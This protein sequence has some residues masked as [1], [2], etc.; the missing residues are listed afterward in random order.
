MTEDYLQQRSTDEIQNQVDAAQSSLFGPIAAG[1]GAIAIGAAVYSTKMAGGGRLI[2]N[3]LHFLGHPGGVGLKIDEAANAAAK[4]GTAGIN[5]VLTANISSKTGRLFL[6]P[7]DLISDTRSALDLINSVIPAERSIARDVTKEFNKAVHS[8]LANKVSS[9]YFDHGLQ[10]ISV[11][12]VLA[13]QKNWFS[14]IGEEQWTTLKRGV[15]AGLIDPTVAL[16]KKIY[17]AQT[18]VLRDLRLS[19]IFTRPVSVRGPSGAVYMERAPIFDMFGQANTI[20]GM[21]GESRRF[22][23]LASDGSHP[24]TRIFIDG[25]VYGYTRN[26]SGNSFTRR[27]LA[28]ERSLLKSDS[29]LLPVQEAR[30]GTLSLRLKPRTGPVGEAISAFERATGVGTSFSSKSSFLESVLL[31]PI[32]RYRALSSGDA[33]IYR[34]SHQ[35]NSPF[36]K[37]TQS[38]AT[39]AHPEAVFRHGV[40]TP[41]TGGD[42][43]VDMSQ[44]GFFDRLA[45]IFDQADNLSVVS[46]KAYNEYRAGAKTTVHNKDLIVPRKDKGIV[47]RPS[48]FNNTRV[49]SQLSDVDHTGH[50]SSTG[51]LKDAGQAK[52]ID[53]PSSRLTR[54]QSVR[55][56]FPG[57]TS[58]R[59]L[60]NYSIWRTSALASESLLGIAFAPAK[61]FV[62]NVA[63]MAAIPMLYTAGKRAYEYADYL[64]EEYLGFSPTK[65]AATIYAKARVAQ[66]EVR[67]ALGIQQSASWL[68][69]NFPGSIESDGAVLGR[70]IVAPAVAM[71]MFLKKGMFGAGAAAAAAIYSAIGGIDV[72]QTAK[73]LADE[74]AGETKTP[75]RKNRFWGLGYTPFFGG[76]V[77]YYDY[78]WY[79]KLQTDADTKGLYGS[80]SEYF[81]YHA[82]VLGLPFPTPHN[83]FGLRNLMNPYR[84][85]EL[86]A[87]DRPYQYTGSSL[88]E[89]PI[90]GPL[91]SETL[92]RL[93]K[94][95]MMRQMNMPLLQ[96][97]LVQR[98]LDPDTAKLLGMSRLDMSE[99]QIT[100]PRSLKYKLDKLANVA[101]EPTGVYKFVMEFFG[102]KFGEEKEA[103]Y[104]TSDIATSSGRRFYDAALG[105]ML[106]QTE[107]MRRFLL[108]DYNN[109]YRNA[110]LV[111]NIR[112]TM[113]DWLPGAGSK[114]KKDQDY[115]LDFT[116]GDP[117]IKIARGE[118][119]LP[120]PAYEALA[121]FHSGTPGIYSD[122][123]K[124]M[125]LADVAPYSQAYRSY[126]KKVQ[127]MDLDP[128]WKKKVE[129]T[130]R[131]RQES[132]GVDT[133][134]LR[135]GEQLSDLNQAIKDSAVYVG[136]RTAYDALTHDFLAELPYVGSKLFP[137]RNPYEQ[138]RKTQV[139][140]SEFASWDKPYEGVIRP[141]IMDMASVNPIMG[142][143]KGAAV[144]ALLSGPMSS[145]N[146]VTSTIGNTSMMAARGAMFGG[147]LSTARILGGYSQD[148]IPAHKKQEAD[149]VEYMDAVNYLKYNAMAAAAEER[150]IPSGNIRNMMGRTML[151]AKNNLMIRSTL[152]TS[153][154]RKYFEYFMSVNPSMRGQIYEG[155]PGYMKDALAKGW[156]HTHNT[157]EQA[158][159]RA[160]MILNSLPADNWIG[161]HPD[162]P[163]GASKIHLINHGINGVSEN[164]HRF[165]FYESQENDI[166]SRI[167]DFN[168][169]PVSYTTPQTSQ[170]SELL[171]IQKQSYLNQ[172]GGT[173]TSSTHFTANRMHRKFTVSVDRSQDTKDAVRHYVR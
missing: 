166:L 54:F 147:G 92:G 127:G 5:S 52:Y 51:F 48:R 129:D 32:K 167:P 50:L 3:L 83:L 74:Y 80:K 118:S 163:I 154:D 13:D 27:L 18:G 85:E 46:T 42:A 145:F 33:V 77:D 152:P 99:A 98:G 86:H 161:W 94:P 114:F 15:D 44:L 31:D 93:I 159:E 4:S 1:I 16:D 157:P 39:R 143:I 151:G 100:D 21:L 148:F 82:N 111:N 70:S 169:R 133:R 71:S 132:I 7:V 126:A 11:S 47:H 14:I 84:F 59:T 123:D 29:P 108:P 10:R 140:G 121:K 81:K 66:Q 112:N 49:A 41:V 87:S 69:K 63:R 26:A 22:A 168:D 146:P 173:A 136:A 138:Y 75:V 28:T 115:F 64:S 37:I 139:E 160:Q 89:F 103:R 55:D 61:S 36:H 142:A 171:A 95:V 6:G 101:L 164:Y 20:M 56:M 109:P 68:E 119:R 8:R 65:T 131:Y 153:S 130:F 135:Y 128:Y 45:V 106:E 23:A 117:Y 25:N 150:G 62:G 38:I 90:V 155:V 24:G 88:E 116:A 76:E 141:M 122:V 17:R 57:L 30:D 60:A 110:D 113:P 78:S 105:G 104:A 124:F 34:H 53:V 12:E 144:G 35:Y 73:E 170:Y 134:Y 158:Q 67:S 2:S 91:L 9:G 102:V 96:A 156:S 79:H 43:V 165:G 58:F 72:G 19:S 172:M 97:G 137:F 107:F 125:V 149:T 40:V 120:G 162:I